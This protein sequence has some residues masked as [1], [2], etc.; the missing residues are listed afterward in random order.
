MSSISSV[1]VPAFVTKAKSR[2]PGSTHPRA[3][4]V[5]DWWSA[6]LLSGAARVWACLRRGA[7]VSGSARRR[8]ARGGVVQAS[9]ERLRMCVHWFPRR[10]RCCAGSRD[11]CAGWGR[12]GRGWS[13]AR[14]ALESL[15]AALRRGCHPWRLNCPTLAGARRVDSRRSAAARERCGAR[16][17]VPAARRSCSGVGA[18]SNGAGR[19]AAS[20][21]RAV[22]VC[23]LAAATRALLRRLSGACAGWGRA[24]RG[25][26]G[27]RCALGRLCGAR[28]VSPL[29]SELPY[30]GA[31]STSGCLCSFY[32]VRRASGRAC[33]AAR[34][35]QGRR[36]SARCKAGQ[37]YAG[38]A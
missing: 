30:P 22:G 24:G 11:A 18:A 6:R 37:V 17:G 19:R 14:C 33:D 1:G 21:R 15:R 29:A 8:T 5:G 28:Q 16:L 7:A 20:L 23:A 27:A 32:K 3:L 34:R 13:G 31:A 12:A 26:H 36:D 9:G 38:Q 35:F 4:R 2:C 10:A 25:W